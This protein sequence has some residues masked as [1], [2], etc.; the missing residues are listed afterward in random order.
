M[1][2]HTRSQVEEDAAR[3]AAQG[4][5]VEVLGPDDVTG[6]WPALSPCA[7]PVD[8][9]RP[10]LHEC[11]PGEAFLF[12]PTGGYADPVAAV[13]DLH[14]AVRRL[15]GSVKFSTPVVGVVES[16]GRIRGVELDRGRIS[17]DLVVNAAGPWCNRL[18]QMA[19]VELGWTLT[20]TRIQTLVRTW[21]AE[22]GPLPVGA[23]ASTGIYFR[24][25]LPDRV[26]VGSVAPEDEE[27]IV[28]DPDSYRTYPDAEFKTLKMAAFHHRV[29]AL[30]A[31]GDVGG[32]CGLYT[33]NREDVHPVLGPSGVD[34]F[35]LANGF[36]GH[37]F[38]L[39]PAV[40]ALLARHYTGV[41]LEDDPDVDLA[42]LA[43][44][45]QPI[46]VAAKHV[47]A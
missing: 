33:I 6:R 5:E 17:A 7:E 27:E 11:R 2:G 30:E 44:D 38:K 26:M 19:G 47:L 43:V 35:W 42:L 15:G 1:L 39:A 18:N 23:D 28:P 29:P 8:L 24:P 41:A 9:D 34:G 32:I 45:R 31:R 46:R 37:G 3:L 25:E 4:V 36:S 16:E 40:G 22:L 13:Q 14:D 20:P 21:P 10:D 12:E